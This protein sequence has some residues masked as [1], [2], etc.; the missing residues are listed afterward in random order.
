MNWINYTP[1]VYANLRRIF[2]HSVAE[3][4]QPGNAMLARTNRIQF[5]RNQG[6][7]DILTGAWRLTC[8]K[9]IRNNPSR[10]KY[11]DRFAGL[12]YPVPLSELYSRFSDWMFLGIISVDPKLYTLGT[13]LNPL[14]TQP[15][16]EFM[17]AP[18]ARAFIDE[19]SFIYLPVSEFD[20]LNSIYSKVPYVH[21]W[22]STSEEAVKTFPNAE[23]LR[24]EV[25][26][27]SSYRSVITGNVY[28]PFLPAHVYSGRTF[29]TPA[30]TLLYEYF[31][32]AGYHSPLDSTVLS[33][34]RPFYLDFP[35]GVPLEGQLSYLESAREGLYP[36]E[37][38]IDQVG[39][40]TGYQTTESYH[41]QP[42]Y[43]YQRQDHT[44]FLSLHIPI[45]ETIPVL[46]QPSFREPISQYEVL[47]AGL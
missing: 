41:V 15:A 27:E 6:Y 37:G 39:T 14:V 25:P 42:W 13:E 38:R 47:G 20:E 7:T 40:Y 30:K 24:L 11:L 36:E 17:Y 23:P 12:Q 32:N 10:F 33:P 19:C 3:Y 1:E 45:R 2:Q 4:F 43:L 35:L 46:T 31:D 29:L 9:Q 8:V 44:V 18:T 21:I 16:Y 34:E 5:N 22:N 28:H 26:I